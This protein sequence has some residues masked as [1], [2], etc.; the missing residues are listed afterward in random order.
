MLGTYAHLLTSDANNAIL[1]ENNLAPPTAKTDA[2]TTT[3][4]PTCHELNNGNATYCTKRTNPLDEK[5]IHAQQARR[6]QSEALL[7]Q[8]IEAL[9]HKGLL[10]DAADVVHSTG[11]AKRL[12]NL[13]RLHKKEVLPKAG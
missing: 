2:L 6:E 12:E 3:V 13:A 9:V 11:L 4:C 7:L 10:D 8:V 5:Y 1:A